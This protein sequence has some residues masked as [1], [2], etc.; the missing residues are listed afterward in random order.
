MCRILYQKELRIIA[1]IKALVNEAMDGAE[2]HS[3]VEDLSVRL[4]DL[5][6]RWLQA[7]ASKPKYFEFT[8]IEL[9]AITERMKL[10][11]PT[12]NG[13]VHADVANYVEFLHR[14]HNIKVRGMR[15]YVGTSNIIWNSLPFSLHL[16]KNLLALWVRIHSL[17][18]SGSSISCILSLP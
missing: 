1:A 6:D 5:G 14:V 17:V 2:V 13:D 18:F 15:G 3:I 7:S 9:Y 10:A 16:C 4:G 8:P 12:A 11:E